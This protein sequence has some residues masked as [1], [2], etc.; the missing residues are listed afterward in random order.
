M[1]KFGLILHLLFDN[2]IRVIWQ[3]EAGG[4]SVELPNPYWL[5]VESG[6]CSNQ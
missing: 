6:S 5:E 2:L 1:L 3:K 4:F